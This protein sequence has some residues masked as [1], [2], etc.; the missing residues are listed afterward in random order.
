MTNRW[1]IY[2]AC[3]F[4]L[5]VAGCTQQ[6]NP[7]V[8]GTVYFNGSALGDGFSN[9]SI[10]VGE[11]YNVSNWSTDCITLTANGDATVES[12]ILASWDT[13]C[14][15]DGTHTIRLRVYDNTSMVAEDYVYVSINNVEVSYPLAGGGLPRNMN[16]PIEG[17]VW[18]DAYDAYSFRYGF[19]DNITSWETD[20]A[21]STGNGSRI[22][23]TIGFF[24][25]SG[26]SVGDNVTLEINVS[27]S[28]GTSTRENVSFTIDD[29]QEGWPRAMDA[30]VL[31]GGYGVT[32]ADLD[33]D[34]VLDVIGVSSGSPG[35][36]V[37]AWHANGSRMAGWPVD[38]PPGVLQN[39]T[40]GL[41]SLDYLTHPAVGDVDGE[42]GLEIFVVHV[43]L[44]YP[45]HRVYAWHANGTPLTGWPITITG[46]VY[47]S[48]TLVDL[49]GDG[50]REIIVAGIY[51]YEGIENMS[52]Y[53]T[54]PREAL[55][56]FYANGST[57]DG[58]GSDLY[59]VANHTGL[60]IAGVSA[61]D[62]D[63]DGSP[64]LL[65]NYFFID[66]D[67]NIQESRLYL[68]NASG[69]SLTGWPLAVN[70]TLTYD[71]VF[72]DVD[73]DGTYEIVSYGLGYNNTDDHHIYVFELNGS[74]SPGWPAALN[75][76]HTTSPL[77]M[78]SPL[79]LGNLDDDAYLEVV[80]NTRQRIYV[81][82][83]DG[84]L[85]NGFPVEPNVSSSYAPVLA[86]LDGDE[87]T[88]IL[89]VGGS[90]LYAYDAQG[91]SI[92]GWPKTCLN[93]IPRYTPAV[94]DVDA[95]G[96]IEIA[97]GGYGATSDPYE[98]SQG[99]MILYDYPA[100]YNESHAYWKEYRGDS[101]RTAAASTTTTSIPTHYVNITNTTYQ[102]ADITINRGDIVVWTNLDT[103]T[104]TVTSDTGGFFDSGDI[105]ADASWNRSFN[106]IGN[107]TY[108][109]TYQLGYNGSVY[110][111]TPQSFGL[112]GGW[113]LTALAVTP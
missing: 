91:D 74:I 105:A 73:A 96:D 100:S 70:D 14:Y 36:K 9:F 6:N 59:T 37:F 29:Y 113:N 55:Y 22:S 93:G 103:L 19:G 27:F 8:N 5:F 50:R 40:G 89:I 67:G 110:V 20:R 72:G 66:Q 35:P 75:E 18:S 69:E 63:E 79:A 48:P 32:F 86:D 99:Y 81:W 39:I 13:G 47:N 53:A 10:A 2:F 92:S 23:G 28:S 26:L 16:A 94:D 111:L 95:D 58:F 1:S 109:C 60:S 25:T 65:T 42:P 77:T 82:E 33:N 44:F 24:N 52:E 107:H 31:N 83:H 21:T 97:V 57:V 49:T 46:V 112:A 12:D 56:A 17:K 4:V 61:A 45:Y 15:P 90:D 76:T 54:D 80:I 11:G 43:D 34:S 7:V 101:L 64:E 98:P 51:G 68:V 87:Q 3:V 88:D 62:V 104:H 41:L 38:V 85:R 71:S 30:D 84:S 102:P 108:H 106:S 78:H